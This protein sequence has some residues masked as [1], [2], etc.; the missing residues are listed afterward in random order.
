MAIETNTET[1]YELGSGATD[2]VREDLANIIY[3]ISPTEV[4]FQSNVRREA[5]ETDYAEWL[6]DDLAPA[7]NTPR[8]DGDEFSG[9]ELTPGDRLG[10]YHQISRKDLVVSRRA[11]IV[12]KAGRLTEMS[13]QIAKAA[14]ELRR[15]VETGAT[16]RQAAVP[17]DDTTAPQTAGVPAWIRTNLYRGGGGTAPT[18]S[19]GTSGYPNSAGTRALGSPLYQDDLL[20]QCRN[21]Y[22]AGGAPNMM[23]VP[24]GLKRGLSNYLF[25]NDSRRV[26]TPYQDHGSAP[27][28]GVSVIGAVDVYVTDF[29]VLDIVPNRF[30]PSANNEAELYI[31]DTDYWAVS[32]LDGYHIETIGQVGDASRQMLIVDWAV[33]SRNEAASAILADLRPDV[34]V[35]PGLS[36]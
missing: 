29:Q 32:F 8:I 22:D 15:D 2:N 9:D 23:M 28:G 3:N 25:T 14:K 16:L 17:G 4:P 20:E 19:A 7:S 13:Y 31:L 5:S 10:N 26:A 34:P 21:A 35:Q 18:L 36:P 12:D 24:L 27:R 33:I 30:S 11:D 1:R 6:I